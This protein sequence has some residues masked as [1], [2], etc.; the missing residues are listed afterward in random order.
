V[1]DQIAALADDDPAR[2]YTMDEVESEQDEMLEFIRERAD[3]LSDLLG[4]H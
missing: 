3:Q 2:P 1:R 4:V